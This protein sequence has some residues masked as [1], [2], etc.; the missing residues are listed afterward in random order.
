MNFAEKRFAEM[1]LAE[2]SLAE[3]IES[4]A[5]NIFAHLNVS[6]VIFAQASSR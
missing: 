4:A 6:E 5:E 2:M 1:K 3:L